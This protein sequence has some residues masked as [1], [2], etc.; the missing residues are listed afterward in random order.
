MTGSRVSRFILAQSLEQFGG[1]RGVLVD[2]KP[3]THAEFGVVL[4]ERI[5][6]GRAA[7]IG[8]LSPGRGRQIA[9]KAR[10]LS[11]TDLK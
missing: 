8:V 1:V 2:R 9:A 4:E 6:P 5:R 7:T 11:C 3:H 10:Q